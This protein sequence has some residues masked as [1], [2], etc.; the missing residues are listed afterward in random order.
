LMRS[1]YRF[2]FHAE[3]SIG[4]HLPVSEEAIRRAIPVAIKLAKE[5]QMI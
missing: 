3:R 4:K 1:I 5:L 2:H